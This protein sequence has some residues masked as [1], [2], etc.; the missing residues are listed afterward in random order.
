ML[1]RPRV[2]FATVFNGEQID[3]LS[4]LQPKWEQTWNPIE[5][6]EH[7]LKTS[8]AVMMHRF[9]DRAFYAQS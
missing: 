7:I 4:L 2:F 9:G 6:A 1:E 8:G 5:R 3:G